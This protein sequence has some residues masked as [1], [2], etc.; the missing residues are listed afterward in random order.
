MAYGNDVIV[1][2]ALGG[3]AESE[4]LDGPAAVTSAYSVRPR[5]RR[6]FIGGVR[7]KDVAADVEGSDIGE[8]EGKGSEGLQHKCGLI[9]WLIILLEHHNM[10]ILVPRYGE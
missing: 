6:E 9:C 4:G 8:E 2:V 10:F 7:L 1:D 5:D 3:G